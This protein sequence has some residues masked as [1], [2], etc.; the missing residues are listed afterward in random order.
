M[1]SHYR[2]NRHKQILIESTVVTGLQW[3]LLLNLTTLFTEV[4]RHLPKLDRKQLFLCSWAKES[5]AGGGWRQDGGGWRSPWR[6]P[7]L[8]DAVVLAAGVTIGRRPTGPSL[9]PAVGHGVPLRAWCCLQEDNVFRHTDKHVTCVLCYRRHMWAPVGCF[10]LTCVTLTLTIYIS[11]D[12]N[13]A[14]ILVCKE[15]VS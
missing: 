2:R 14:F 13:S 11:R 8:A 15:L 7:L 9:L 3:I 10:T 6:A 5:P 4:F 12:F 1:S